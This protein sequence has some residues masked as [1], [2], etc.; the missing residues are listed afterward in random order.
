MIKENIISLILEDAGEEVSVSKEKK[1]R[2]IEMIYSFM[3]NCYDDE[4]Y[5]DEFGNVSSYIS[6][7]VRQYI[8]KD[9]SFEIFKKCVNRAFKRFHEDFEGYSMGRKN[10]SRVRRMMKYILDFYA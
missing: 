9:L 6:K 2:L 7:F 10:M 8:S 3:E 1:E 4:D 5:E